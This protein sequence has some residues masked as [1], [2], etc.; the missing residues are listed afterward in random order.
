MAQHQSSIQS[1]DRLLGLECLRFVAAL[2]VLVFHCEHFAY[3]GEVTYNLDVVR[4]PFYS[5]L[6]LIYVHGHYGVQVFWCISGYIFFWKYRD[7]IGARRMSARSFFILRFSRLYPLHFITLLIAAVFQYLYF[8]QQ[9]VF[10]V[11]PAN[12]GSHFILQLFMASNWG[13]E[14]GLGFNGPIWSVSMEVL[15]YI[16]FFIVL[17]T[18]GASFKMEAAIIL[19][20]GLAKIFNPTAKIL[21]C[22]ALFYIGGV[23]ANLSQMQWAQA[24]K[25]GLAIIGGLALVLMPGA[26]LV[27]QFIHMKY[28]TQLF[29]MAYTPLLIYVLA[30]FVIVPRRMQPFVEAAGHMTYA[31]YLIHFPMQLLV[32]VTSAQ[33]GWALPIYSNF[34]FL[35]YLGVVLFG[36]RAVYLRFEMPMQ[37]FIRQK[38]N[39][40]QKGR[41]KSRS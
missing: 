40:R 13:L 17:R 29:I 31:S 27:P 3:R 26:F 10:L 25:R 37:S 22:I 35:V 21:D 16:L 5:V 14:S 6:H 34:F 9:G 24:H 20:C 30:N 11:Y 12:D 41:L 23:M 32:I 2:C 33:M 7:V 28:F 1:V 38:A 18:F 36:A 4:L 8:Q 19:G 39:R 15:V